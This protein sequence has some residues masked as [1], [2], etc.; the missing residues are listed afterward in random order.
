VQK[1][2][3]FMVQHAYDD[4]DEIE[5]VKLIGIY[6]TEEKAKAVVERLKIARVRALSERLPC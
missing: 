5:H 6:T 1:D 2:G 4:A 3:A